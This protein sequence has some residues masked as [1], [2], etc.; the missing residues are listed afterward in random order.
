MAEPG[1]AGHRACPNC[2]SD[3]VSRYCAS[4]GQAAPK[5]EDYSLRAHAGELVEQLTSV[6]SK[7]LRTLWT[8]VGRPGELTVD[9][10]A[11]RRA[12]YLRPFQLFLLI[13]ILLFIAAPRMPLFQYSLGNYLQH[14]PPSPTVV[15]DLVQRRTGGSR[16]AQSQTPEVLNA[17][18]PLSEKEKYAAEFDRRVETQRKSFI[19]LFAPALALILWM[20]LARRRKVPGVPGRYGQHLVFALHS[21]AFVW[22]VFVVWGIVA[23]SLSGRTV[24]PIALLWVVPMLL[25]SPFYIFLAT[26]RAYR[27]SR[28][29]ALA[30]TLG[31]T[32]SFVALLG[33]Y[34]SLLFFTAYY[35]L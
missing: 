29:G 19:I 26:R 12:R 1:G 18:L 24:G 35:S 20:V 34:R 6:E 31:L 10:L 27:L 7:A 23:S 33:A 25:S 32:A 21:L 14:A 11:G 9:H 16:N 28:V 22:L 4:C 5:P 8:L 2:G 3:L 13:N 17:V 30:L 15:R